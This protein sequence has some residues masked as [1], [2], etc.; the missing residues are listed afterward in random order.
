M[1]YNALSQRQ[2]VKFD[3]F[4]EQR[5]LPDIVSLS[6]ELF[7]RT[8]SKGRIQSRPM[9]DTQ[10]RVSDP[11]ADQANRDFLTAD[12]KDRAENLMIVDLL[13]NDLS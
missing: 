11:V 13:R 10:P 3:A 4:I 12:S 9:K 8:N 5:G 2:P 6:P 7:F 1:F